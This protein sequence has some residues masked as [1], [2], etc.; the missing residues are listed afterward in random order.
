[1]NYKFDSDNWGSSFKV[2]AVVVTDFLQISDGDCI[3]VLL[4]ILAGSRIATTQQISAKCGLSDSVVDEAV[5]FWA[6]RDVISVIADNS[7]IEP[8]KRIEPV[9]IVESVKP[10]SMAVEKKIVVN[11]TAREIRE[12]AEHDE[13][14]KVL[15]ND[16]Q[17]LQFSVT[18]KEL[19]RLIELYEVYHFDVPTILLTADYCNS[20]G[21]RSIG[22]LSTVMVN[23]Y[24]EDIQSY[25]E[26]EKKI[27]EQTAFYGYQ[28]RVLRIFGI[29]SKPS[30]K[31]REYIEKWHDMGMP[32]EL[33]EIAYDKCMDSKG[34]FNFS[35]I[36]GII[37]N[38]AANSITTPEQVAISD[39]GFEKKKNFPKPDTAK[40]NS[41]DLDSFEKYAESFSLYGDDDV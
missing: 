30:K 22:Y 19:G 37:K 16:I 34:K 31:Q 4:C 38:W 2:P 14:L 40:Q 39:A 15:I 36:D 8:N 28:C 13:N 5:K 21:K 24:N 20:M 23:W 32:I 1:M 3:K 35:Y 26:V 17:K 10:S 18:G 27:I 11:Y 29:D 12:K 7:A 9:S 41:Y 33:I 25:A 6:Q